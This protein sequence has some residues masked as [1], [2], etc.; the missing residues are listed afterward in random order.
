MCSS[1]LSER[2]RERRNERREKASPKVP[3]LGEKEGVEGLEGRASHDPLCVGSVTPS[4]YPKERAFHDAAPFRRHSTRR[5][6]SETVTL[7]A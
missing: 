3:K 6:R 7:Q 1:D 4:P 2:E 5:R